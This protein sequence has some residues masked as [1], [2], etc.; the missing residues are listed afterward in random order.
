MKKNLGFQIQMHFVDKCVSL[1]Q[2]KWSL[3][4]IT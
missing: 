1:L 2:D 3:G 4:I